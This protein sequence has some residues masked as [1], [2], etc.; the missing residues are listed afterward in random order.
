MPEYRLLRESSTHFSDRLNAL[1]KEGWVI[2]GNIV[3]SD[4]Q[5]AV[6][7]MRARR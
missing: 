2:H 5:I 1:T 4:N 7:L 6:L 3:S